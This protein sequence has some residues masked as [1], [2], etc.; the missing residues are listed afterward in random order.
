MTT[1]PLPPP[2]FIEKIHIMR[3]ALYNSHYNLTAG[4]TDAHSL[5]PATL[6][7]QRIIEIATRHANC[8][9]VGYEQ[10][11]TAGI[12]WV[13]S[14]I[15]L[16]VMRFPRINEDYA[17]NTWIE[18]YNRHFSERAFDM[19]EPGGAAIAAGRS[20]WVAIDMNR[21]TMADLSAFERDAIPCH[22]R[23]CPVAHPRRLAPL[24]AEAT[25]EPIRFGYTDIDF[26]RHV[27]TVRYLARV[28]DHWPLAH[29]DRYAV[30]RLDIAFNHELRYGD[31]ATLRISDRPDGCSECEIL[32]ADG[33]RA[34]AM[35]IHWQLRRDME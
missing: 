35:R 33:R 20:T 24:G 22:D 16:E 14:R 2:F 12:G 28:L 32:H 4:E 29:H 25:S 27:N 13:L 8:L 21:R 7:V 3:Q 15:S 30:R 1:K 6:L 18:S 9:E 34:A 10:L 23:P 5:M 11:R 31:Q 17:L 26:N 19:V